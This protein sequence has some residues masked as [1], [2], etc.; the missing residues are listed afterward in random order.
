MH[1][2][3]A[4]SLARTGLVV[5]IATL[6]LAA[7]ADAAF[8]P[9]SAVY[10]VKIL[11]LSGKLTTRLDKTETGF[12]A[13]HIIRPT[14]MSKV[15]VKGVI[16]EF[17]QFHV[18]DDGIVPDVYRSNDEL[19]KDKTR[20]DLTFDWDTFTANGIVDGEDFS[21]EMGKFAHDRVSIQYQLMQDLMLDD[22]HDTYQLF[23]IDRLKTL[24]ITRIGEKQVKIGPGKFNAIGV[25]H[26]REGSSRVTTFWCVEEFDYL[27][28]VIEQ[29][30]KGKLRMRAVL[31]SYAPAN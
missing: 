27:P 17:S 22:E 26:Q 23:D 4:K 8:T 11:V 10:K 15:F 5:L 19:T 6:G 24:N 16:D 18:T 1:L 7:Q 25:Q 2:R 9:H 20:A 29:H 13:N 31:D 3:I 30:R 21:Y 28:V 12:A 14:G